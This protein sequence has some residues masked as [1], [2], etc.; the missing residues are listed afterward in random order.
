[1]KTENTIKEYTIRDL[2]NLF[3]SKLF[4]IIVVTLVFGVAAY[5]IANWVMPRKYSS[6]ISMYVQSY[7]AD[8]ATDA[9][10]RG[11]VSTSKQLLN[12]YIEV[13]KDDAVMTDVGNQLAKYFTPEALRECFTL[14]DGSVT[15]S[16]LRSCIKITAVTDTTA[17]TVTATTKNAEIS[18]AVCNYL[19]RVAQKYLDKAVGVGSINYIATARIYETPVSPNIPKITLLGA[20]IGF[21][22]IIFEVLAIDF[23]DNTIK[24]TQDLSDKFNIASLGEI[25][26]MGGGNDK[27]KKKN[28]NKKSN[29]RSKM[30]LTDKNT[31]F[32][33]IES[34]KSIRTNITFSLSTQKRKVFAVSSANPGEGK[35][36]TAANIAIAFAQA[37]SNVL[38]IDADMRKPVQHKTFRVS[39]IDGLST[40]IGKMSTV[41]DAV[42]RNV[43]PHLDVLPAGTCPPNPSELLASEQFAE[44][45][46]KLSERYDYVIIDTPPVNVVSDAIVLRDVIGGVLF[47]LRY[48]ATTYDDVDEAMK[49]VKLAEAKTIGFIMNDVKIEHRGGYYAKDKYSYYKYG[50]SNRGSSSSSAKK[51]DLD[52]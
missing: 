10:L 17:L 41:E 36:T 49:K 7:T 20:A 27:K 1:M 33:V 25:Q 47:V 3:L 37:E 50:Y 52:D 35:S 31:P 13:L 2:I 14:R 43:L 26:S 24:G 48:G 15:P 6:H 46:E 45:I 21:A 19:S 40:L 38:L 18:A 34:Y 28:K 5:C 39:N 4:T 29:D 23:F 16:S 32:N 8:S 9:E 30:L 12:T 22:L 11:S 51:R 42:K 44:L